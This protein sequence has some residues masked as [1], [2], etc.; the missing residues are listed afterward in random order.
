[1]STAPSPPPSLAPIRRSR[2]VACCLLVVGLLFVQDAGLLVPDTKFDLVAAPLDWLSRA[3]HVWDAEGGFGQVQNQAH[4][5]LWPMG[6]FFA[7]L[8]SLGIPGWV[9]QRLWQSLVVG[10]ALVGLARLARALGVRSD[11]A[12]L[13]AG[14]AYALSPRM[15]T[16]LGPISIEVWPSALAPWVLLPLVAGA[17]R[18]SPRRAAALSGLA[19]AMVGGVNAAASF[20]VVPLAV[21][22]ILTRTPGPRRRALMLWWPVFT[23]L[24]TAWWIVPLLVMGRVSPP[25]LDYTETSALTTFPTTVFDVLRGTSHWVP[26]LDPASRAGNDI[27]TTGWVAVNTAVLVILGLVGLLHRRTPQ[28]TFLVL[29]LLT[30]VLLVAAGHHGA[31][32]GWFAGDV[33]AQLDG[34][35][36]PLRNV[37][38]FDPVV[39]VPLLVGLAFALDR[40]LTR[41]RDRQDGARQGARQGARRDA[42]VLVGA[43]VLGIVGA[44]SPVITDR[45][46]AAGATLGVPDYWRQAADDVARRSTGGTTLVVPGSRFAEYLWGDPR[47]EPMQWLAG[48]R[49][50]V[51]SVGILAEPGLIRMLDGFER[52]FAEGHGSAGLTAALRRAGVEQVVVR[53]DLRPTD[54]VPSPALV[55][56]AIAD[57]PGLRRVA[58]FGPTIG[59]DAL[60][61]EPERRVVLDGGRQGLYPA[62]EV[63]A[64][65]GA[66]PAAAVTD[67]TVVAAGGDDLPD[68]L[69][70][71][72]LGAAPV[73]LATEAAPDGR[74]AEGEPAGGR[75]RRVVLT[76]GLRERERQFG[77]LHDGASA[78][79]T[80]GDV[81]RTQGPVRDVLPPGD[82]GDRWS[83]TSRLV[84]ASAIAASSS[85][86]DADALGGSDRGRLPYAAIDDAP[87]TAWWSALGDVAP[88]WQVTFE[89]DRTVSSVRL[90]A[91]VDAPPQLL[92]VV[93]RAG[94]S[95]PLRL[96]PGGERTIRLPADRAT[97]WLRVEAAVAAR[98][99]AGERL[100]LAEVVVPGLAV[101]R[102]LDLPR[103][104]QAWG[105]P[106]VVSLRADRD[107]RSGCVDTS[108]VTRCA[109]GTARTG[110]D[111][112]RLARSFELGAAAPYDLAVR[113]VPRGGAALDAVLLQGQPADVEVST[114]ALDDPR[115]GAVAA[116]DGSPD[117]AWLAGLDDLQ[118]VVRLGWL[119]V[120]P[121]TGIRLALAPRTAAR[122]PTR[123][124][125]VFSDGAAATRRI[126]RL[127]SD[128]S[129]RV[130]RVRADRV[131]ITV[132]DAD[133]VADVRPDGTVAPA[134]IGIGEITLRGLPILPLSLPATPRRLACGTGP[135]V[136]VGDR[137]VA[138]AVVASARR[139]AS[140]ATVPAAVCGT[141]PAPARI[142]APAGR[143]E[144]LAQPSSA[145]AATSVVLRS[146]RDPGEPLPTAADVAS[147]SPVSRTVTAAGAEPAT[148]SVVALRESANRGWRARRGG[149]SL[150]PVVLD[151]WQQGF[152]LGPDPAG[153]TAGRPDVVRVAVDFAP[154]VPY[155]WGLGLGAV[156]ALLLLLAVAL[157]GRWRSDA[158]P[159]GDRALRRP[160][161]AAL[162]FGAAGLLAGGVGVLVAA[163]VAGALLTT[164]WVA[165]ALD[166]RRDA[167]GE[168]RTAGRVAD[169]APWLL[170]APVL[171]VGVGYALRPWGGVQPWAGTIGWL[172][173]LCLVPLVA[174][175]LTLAPDAPDV[176]GRRG[177]RGRRRSTRRIAGR[178]TKR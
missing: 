157:S 32:Q 114:T 1:M 3:L 10:V 121:I 73:R 104:P 100:A 39:R 127:A 5:Y 38:K 126:V 42:V 168:G 106:D 24:G 133:A 11:L 148:G 145:F 53:N 140:G 29:G 101:R 131:E 163:G 28:R 111:D 142:Q 81:R 125:L 23:A 8:H 102:V 51:R 66:R 118:P 22:W 44:A 19:V 50:A 105:A 45:A 94:A 27:I 92:R 47:D 152:R 93:T 71:G 137:T 162:A 95:Q 54:D 14:F 68:L 59:G 139:L 175:P 135:T 122:R 174:L 61:V 115:A 85:A 98:S 74:I 6:P 30:G 110:E 76:D 117:T 123:V 130:P 9:V 164:R 16:S 2:L 154:D 35:L 89:R 120:R 173:Y 112:A 77:R 178:S 78:T 55:H 141:G 161:A 4:G 21:V 46:E 18:G 143:V 113:A 155:R 165:R 107:A 169:A 86:A 132:L 116:I 156:L 25:F 91:P 48:S 160:L 34:A 159:A 37:H 63:Y 26:Y 97:R 166:R 134:P 144:V 57:S 119:G 129:A 128:G 33:S 150:E 172:G 136:R 149:R 15:L 7:L 82:A 62:V 108:G 170:A 58:T 52:R 99:A 41:A 88:R 90:S 103:L 17:E 151:G 49:W 75:P 147:S 96:V 65:P 171:A 177:R 72:V 87:R 79:L 158:P 84:G 31:V 167:G 124:S 12:C 20:A 176:P 83:T 67:P 36:G 69:D 80:P 138:T 43:V 40:A 60:V 13:A 146:P 64:V 56:Q 109:A 70:D 153:P